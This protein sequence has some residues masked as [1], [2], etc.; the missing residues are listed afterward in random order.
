MDTFF[1]LPS[2]VK[3]VP[4]NTTRPLSGTGISDVGTGRRT[5]VVQLQTLLRRCD[6]RQYRQSAV[7]DVRNLCSPVDP[8]LDVTRRTVLLRQHVGPDADLLLLVS[9]IAVGSTNLWRDHER[10]HRCARSSSLVQRLD[11][12][13]H[14]N[15]QQ[16]ARAP[17]R[18]FHSRMFCSAIS[19][20]AISTLPAAAAATHIWSRHG[21]L[22]LALECLERSPERRVDKGFC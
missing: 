1:S 15:R 10:D 14:L 2:S 5:A 7:S 18:T 20:D 8:T 11:E 4:T 19:C 21:R 13:F 16:A 12:L 22:V 17:R 9:F 3:I 6:R